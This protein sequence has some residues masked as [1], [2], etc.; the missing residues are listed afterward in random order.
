MKTRSQTAR[1]NTQKVNQNKRISRNVV[2]LIDEYDKYTSGRY[3]GWRDTYDREYNIEDMYHVN[4]DS[5]EEDEYHYN[6]NN[7]RK[8]VR[9]IS[10]VPDTPMKRKKITKEGYDTSDGFV[11]NDNIDVNWSDSEDEV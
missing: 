6:D 4:I 10:R 3:H 2:R 9:F 5:D 11:V 7:K 8:E 1:V